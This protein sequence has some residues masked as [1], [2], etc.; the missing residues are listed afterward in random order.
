M[1]F[2]VE[3]ILSRQESKENKKKNRMK[4]QIRTGQSGAEQK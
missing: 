2:K 3:R 4:D 1:K